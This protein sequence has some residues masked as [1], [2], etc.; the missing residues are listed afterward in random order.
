MTM[1][2]ALGLHA[3]PGAL[4]R[5]PDPSAPAV[6]RLY[7]ASGYADQDEAATI[8]DPGESA[9]IGDP[10]EISRIGDTDEDAAIGDPGGASKQ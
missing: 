4:A 9:A 6:G 10:G 2:M 3:P 7:L 8:G 5:S 1:V